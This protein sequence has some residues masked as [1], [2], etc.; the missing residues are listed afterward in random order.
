MAEST[1]EPSRE[2]LKVFQRYRDALRDGDRESLLDVFSRDSC[3]LF[4]GSDER[5]WFIGREA[6][7]AWTLSERATEMSLPDA[8]KLREGQTDESINAWQRGPIGWIDARLR[9]PTVTGAT[10]VTRGTW[11]FLLEQGQ[12]RCVRAHVS[13][14]VPNDDIFGY[15]PDFETLAAEVAAEQPALS[16]ASSADGI[17]TIAF[18]DIEGSTEILERL[19]DR[20]WMELLRWHDQLVVHATETSGGDVV[21]SQGD[22]FMLAFPSASGALDAALA[23]QAASATGFADQPVRI[24]IGMHAGD[25]VKERVDFFGHTVVVAARVAVQALGGEVLA[26]DAVHDLATGLHRFQFGPERSLILKGIRSPVTVRRVLPGG[27]SIR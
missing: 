3:A 4:I 27:S 11:L 21:K 16:T 12:W 24:R 7:V 13:V 15:S 25:A 18:T 10:V 23:I 1:I 14:P 19:G 9:T 5:E 20:R 22:G 17:M 6:I 26:T 2:L 8:R